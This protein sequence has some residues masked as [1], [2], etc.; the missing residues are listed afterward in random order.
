MEHEQPVVPVLEEVLKENEHHQLCEK[1]PARG[2]DRMGQL[3]PVKEAQGP[4]VGPHQEDRHHVSSSD[5]AD[6]ARD[7]RE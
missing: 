3:A 6:H 5:W 2:E 7:P 1:Q 4:L